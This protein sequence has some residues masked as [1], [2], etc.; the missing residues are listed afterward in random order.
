M[1]ALLYLNPLNYFRAQVMVIGLGTEW[2]DLFR[3]LR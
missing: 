2:C 1:S 3:G